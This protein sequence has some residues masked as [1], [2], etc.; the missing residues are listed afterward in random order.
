M[1]RPLFRAAA[2]YLLATALLAAA[3]LSA[4]SR[5]AE[6]FPY[7]GET[8]GG[9]RGPV[10]ALVYDGADHLL[11]AGADGFLGLW[12]IRSNA[13]EDRFQLSSYP[14]T[15]MALRPEKTHIALIEGDGLGLYRIS[16]WDYGRKET[17][18]TLRFR[19][20]ISYITYSGGGNFLIVSRSARTGV[21]F[22]HPETGEVLQSPEDLTGSVSFAATG[23]SERT[24][25]SYSPGGAL[26]YWE[27]D[28]GREIR[29]FTVPGQMESPILFGNN[30]FFGG[31]DREGLVILDAVS[32]NTLIR[33][34]RFLR[35]RLF[36]VDPALAEFICLGTEGD[37]PVL[38]HLGINGAGE[39]EIRERRVSPLPAALP[40]AMPAAVS[41]AAA[42]YVTALGTSD[43]S[44]WTLPRNG[45]ARAMYTRAPLALSEA[46]AAGS[47]LAFISGGDR[48]GFI[49]RD[50]RELYDGGVIRLED[51]GGYTHITGDARGGPFLLWQTSHNRSFPLVRPSPADGGPGDSRITLQNLPARFP[52]RSASILGD[53][54]LFLDSA[55]NLT[56][57]SLDT[58]A[59]RFSFSSAGSLDA[60]FLDQGNII[61]GRSAVSGNTPFLLV[62]IDTGE[63]VPFAYP[64]S[65]GVRVYRGGSGALYGAVVNED[66]GNTKTSILRLNPA[67]PA[68]SSPLVDYQGE[69]TGFSLAESGGALASTIGGDGATLYGPRG[70]I[71]FERGPGIP[72]RLIS[73]G[74]FFITLD[75]DGNLCWHE[76]QGGQLLATLRLYENEWVLTKKT[77]EVIRGALAGPD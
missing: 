77:G 41:A 28:T 54:A 39:L 40:A 17:L 16:V 5:D 14:I 56:V 30:R 24:M 65:I 34:G 31:I 73:G 68:V 71:A 1:T 21:V 4:Q 50:Y 32:G 60:A 38:Y 74:D 26:S 64:A 22:I 7:P 67:N 69:D 70:F 57:I 48:L 52:I 12:N 44:V 29:R 43:G 76:N 58:G 66:R 59:V 37:L 23:R 35:A 27:L 20:P 6:L 33:D 75:G 72:V 61:I 9:H 62:N 3:C 47:T 42:G 2:G 13:A 49:P 55:G 53:D 25:I 45:E 10:R 8:R 19:D 63:T 51:A 36:P 18:F 11:S 46:A 15:A